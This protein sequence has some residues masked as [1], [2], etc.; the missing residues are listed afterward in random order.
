MK[1]LC[2]EILPIPG[3]VSRYLVP[4]GN[5][6]D[7][8][9]LGNLPFVVLE[10]ICELV[11][12]V[13]HQIDG[14][15]LDVSGPYFSHDPSSLDAQGMVIGYFKFVDIDHFKSFFIHQ[16]FGFACQIPPVFL[17]IIDA[18][19]F[20]AQY[21]GKKMNPKMISVKKNIYSQQSYPLNCNTNLH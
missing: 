20:D 11:V 19:N 21:R 1:K 15:A 16:D 7:I 8:C 14:D 4:Q 2:L 12:V 17:G 10:V 13:L 9:E 3:D 6:F 18:D 5:G